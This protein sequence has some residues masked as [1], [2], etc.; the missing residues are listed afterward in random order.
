MNP[1]PATSAS[2]AEFTQLYGELRALA[3]VR[4]RRSEPITL[5]DTTNLVHETWLRFQKA[6][7]TDV[8]G[9]AR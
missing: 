1:A 4:L 8:A 3:H 6:G 7:P 5:L 2:G 9:R